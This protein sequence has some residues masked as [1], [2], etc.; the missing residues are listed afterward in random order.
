MCVLIDLI[1][2]FII[3]IHIFGILN[4]LNAILF[5]FYFKINK[6]LNCCSFVT[7]CETLL[8]KKAK[9]HLKLLIAQLS[10]VL[11]TCPQCVCS[12]LVAVCVCVSVCITKLVVKFPFVL[13]FSSLHKPLAPIIICL[14]PFLSALLE[15]AFQKCAKLFGCNVN[16]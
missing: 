14:S 4:S 10:P 15:K 7:P 6:Q 8:G 11:S 12:Q 16:G 13:D 9:V 3:R 2:F 1:L 5:N